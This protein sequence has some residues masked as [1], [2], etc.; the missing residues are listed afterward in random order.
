MKTLLVS[1]A[2]LLA[3]AAPGL[4]QPP[5][6]DIEAAC[7]EGQIVVHLSTWHPGPWY[8]DTWAEMRIYTRRIGVCEAPRLLVGGLAWPGEHEVVDAEA[9]AGLGHGYYVRFVDDEGQEFPPGG[10]YGT[11]D[12]AGC[13]DWILSRGTLHLGDHWDQGILELQPCPDT[14]W[15]EPWLI[16]VTGLESVAYLPLIGHVVDVRG[17]YRYDEMPN[18]PQAVVTSLATAVDGCGP[19]VGVRT[20]RWDQLKTLFR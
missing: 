2:T 20:L 3:L 8:T 4:A 7:V 17:T 13:G 5:P 6:I 11:Y 19:A 15:Y 12:I 10:N 16:D 9:T 18:T 1:I 14:C